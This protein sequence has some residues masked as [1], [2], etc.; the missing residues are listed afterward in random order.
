MPPQSVKSGGTVTTWPESPSPPLW[1]AY[2]AL[3]T[4]SACRMP[5]P[6]LLDQVRIASRMKHFSPRTEKAYLYWIR[7]YIIL[8]GTRHPSELGASEIRAFLGHLATKGRVAASTQNQALSALLFLYRTVLRI[9]LPPLGEVV[10]ARRPARLPVVL[11]RSESSCGSRG[12]DLEASELPHIQVFFR[13]PPAPE[14][15]RHPDRSVMSC[16]VIVM[17]VRR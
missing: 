8:N 13:H 15:V 11:T 17:C 5:A 4:V 6:K 3:S 9:E 7:R 12:A 14:R 10:R 16:L 1:C 2:T